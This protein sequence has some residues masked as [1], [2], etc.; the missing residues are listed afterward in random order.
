VSV[1]IPARD[2]LRWLP[3]ALESI[4]GDPFLEIL[5]VDDGSTD[6]TAEYLDGL[7]G[8]DNRV[9]R[10]VGPCKGPSAARNVA[11]A[12]SA[13][14]LVAFLDADDKW[15]PGKLARHLALHAGNPSV[16]FSFSDYL[17]VDEE[18]T[19]RGAC[20]SYW[21]RFR[22]RFGALREAFD[23][24]DALAHIFA[25]NVIGTST[26]VA[27]TDLLREVGG[28]RT[29]LGSAEDWDLWLK[30]ARLAPVAC[31]P[32]VLADYLMH[33]PGSVSKQ[34]GKRAAAMR[35]IASAHVRHV[36]AAADWARRDCEVRLLVAEAEAA[37]R[38]EPRKALMLRTRVLRLA[39]NRRNL[40]EAARVAA[41]A[42]GY[43]T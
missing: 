38:A 24:P 40:R 29:D 31:I 1:V 22:S 11:L 36:P 6:G 4:G 16:G 30:M 26:V 18:G 17:H 43:V 13:A 7:S 34:A 33:R 3:S 23:L 12:A 35:D 5:V 41:T 32:D 39:P 19:A 8:Q 28:F 10:L 2:A 25:E 21:P 20:L 37:H 27:R 9:R 15:R 14:P 42:L